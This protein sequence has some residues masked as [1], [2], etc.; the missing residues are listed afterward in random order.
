[1]TLEVETLTF[2]ASADKRLAAI[3]KEVL[4]RVDGSKKRLMTVR[5]RSAG[6]FLDLAFGNF[7]KRFGSVEQVGN[8]SGIEFA[9]AEQMWRRLKVGCMILVN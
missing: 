9:N 4:V 5:P 1:V 2:T 3:S 7:A 6:T 8:L